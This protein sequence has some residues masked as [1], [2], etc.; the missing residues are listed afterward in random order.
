MG[1]AQRVAKRGSGTS[2]NADF[3]GQ[4]NK[5]IHGSQAA[6][7]ARLR[8]SFPHMKGYVV[9]A[10][11][12]KKKE[13]KGGGSIPLTP[14]ENIAVEGEKLSGECKDTRRGE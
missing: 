13:R 8:V 1:R 12:Q 3:K 6:A 2:I 14:R 11:R 4:K 10:L 5:L 7:Q 9:E